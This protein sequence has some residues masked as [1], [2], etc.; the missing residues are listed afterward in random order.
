VADTYYAQPSAVLDVVATTGTNGKTSTA[1]WTAQALTRLH[2]RCGVIGTL[3]VGEP[4]PS[5]AAVRRTACAHRPDH[6]RPRH[7]A[8]RLP[9]FCRSGLS[10]CALEAS[11]IGIAE[12]A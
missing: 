6:A 1:W 3:G 8:R 9:R 5:A 7:A 12:G 11:S 10:A 4:P 2:R